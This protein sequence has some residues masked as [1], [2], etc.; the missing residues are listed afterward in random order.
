M[1]KE[2]ILDESRALPWL[3][4]TGIFKRSIQALEGPI[5]GVKRD[6][7]LERREKCTSTNYENSIIILP[8]E[9]NYGSPSYLRITTMSVAAAV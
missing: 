4:S 3:A 9:S 5:L 6:Y 1:S 8:Q 2:N 7:Y